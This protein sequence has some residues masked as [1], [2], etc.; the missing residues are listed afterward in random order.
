MCPLQDCNDRNPL[1]RA[2]AIR[3]MSY[4]H[5][6]AATTALLDPLRHSLKDADPYVRKTAAICVAKLY[7]HDRRIV[8]RQ[9]FIGMLRDLLA[10]TNPTVVAN[11]VAA[12]TE[13]SERSDNIQL[14]LNLTIASKLVSA[15][16]DC[17]ECVAC[18]RS[19][20]SSLTS[21][22]QMGPDLHPRVAHV[23]CA[24]RLRRR[25]DSRR[26]HC[27]APAARQLGRGADERQGDPV[28]HELHRQRRVQGGP[29]PQAEPAARCV[30]PPLPGPCQRT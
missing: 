16:P 27:R 7:M 24:Q 22:A 4:I 25:R 6:P 1:I 30:S 19:A 17:S 9:G 21:P 8:D 3:T 29:V 18:E 13:I 28:P 14:K 2:L 15:L 12:L 11:A 10:D 20:S 26:A 23:L 5:V